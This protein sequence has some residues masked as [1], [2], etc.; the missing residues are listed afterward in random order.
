MYF[1]RSVPHTTYNPRFNSPF[2]YCVY[3]LT[4]SISFKVLDSTGK[5]FF[6]DFLQY[7][8]QFYG[9]SVILITFKCDRNEVAWPLIIPSKSDPINKAE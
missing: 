3:L 5:F 7:F 1:S 9:S 4:N 2:K 8:Y 6:K